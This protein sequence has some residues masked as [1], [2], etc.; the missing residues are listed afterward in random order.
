M[1][2]H[3]L[4]A[5]SLGTIKE[6]AGKLRRIVSQVM[7]KNSKIARDVGNL[8]KYLTELTWELDKL[9]GSEAPELTE[10]WPD[11]TLRTQF[12]SGLSGKLYIETGDALQETLSRVRNLQR[13]CTVGTD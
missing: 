11:A 3:L 2:D 1:D 7:P 5:A 4:M 8:H 10:H 12:G 13:H 9:V 6:E